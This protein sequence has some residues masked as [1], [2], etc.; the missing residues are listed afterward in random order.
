MAKSLKEFR[1]FMDNGGHDEAQRGMHEAAEAEMSS[2]TD[3]QWDKFSE[4]VENFPIYKPG[5]RVRGCR[6]P[7]D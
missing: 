1:E 4:V 5:R 3:E 6:A 2:L 7:I